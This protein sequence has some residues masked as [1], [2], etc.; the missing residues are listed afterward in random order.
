MV[1]SS[2]LAQVQEHVAQIVNDMGSFYWKLEIKGVTTHSF[3]PHI[4]IESL[5]CASTGLRAGFTH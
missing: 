5:L 3:I 2:C 4:F 1:T